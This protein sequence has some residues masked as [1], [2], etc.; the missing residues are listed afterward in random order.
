MGNG[1]CCGENIGKG[2]VGRRG[3]WYTR[4]SVI[5]DLLVMMRVRLMVIVWVMAMDDD[6]GCVKNLNQ[7]HIVF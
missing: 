4:V 2:T 5:I 7:D 6:G 1:E 3:W